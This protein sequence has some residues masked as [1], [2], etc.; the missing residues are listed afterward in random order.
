MQNLQPL[1]SS[2]STGVL[3]TGGASGIGLASARALSAI[4]RPVAIWDIDAR[5]AEA[6]AAQICTEF[7][8]PWNG[9]CGVP[10]IGFGVDVRSP[11]AIAT[12]A[13]ATRQ[14]LPSLGGI[15]HCAGIVD[16]GSLEGITLDS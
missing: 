4:G 1:L 7:G 13:D 6:A 3:V 5:R 16:T 9:A 8:D 11:E 15:V 14:G 2:P 12:A 10:A